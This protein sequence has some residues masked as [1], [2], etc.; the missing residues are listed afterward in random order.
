[1]E[2]NTDNENNIDIN[3]D[4]KKKQE[5]ENDDLNELVESIHDSI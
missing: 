2:G 5:E 3:E 1:M 4:N